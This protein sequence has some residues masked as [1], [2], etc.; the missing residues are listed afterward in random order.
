MKYIFKNR[1]VSK[2]NFT[3]D[4]EKGYNIKPDIKGFDFEEIVLYDKGI[5]QNHIQKKFLFD[6]KKLLKKLLED[7]SEGTANVLTSLDS[8]EYIILNEYKAFLPI[9]VIKNMLKEIYMLKQKFS[10]TFDFSRFNYQEE[11]NNFSVYETEGRGR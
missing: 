4:L 1:R 3:L 11:Y 6:L 10:M 9:E 8:L 5:I 2:T 7:D